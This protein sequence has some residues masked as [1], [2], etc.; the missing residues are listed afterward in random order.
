M[1]CCACVGT[2]LVS[3]N[4]PTST[5]GMATSSKGV[6]ALIV[7]QQQRPANRARLFP[8]ACRSP[9]SKRY[10]HVKLQFHFVAFGPLTINGQVLAR[11]EAGQG[12]AVEARPVSAR[13]RRARA[14]SRERPPAIRAAMRNVT[15]PE[16]G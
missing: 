3:F 4:R 6:V 7:S 12:T 16:R 13:S 14:N 11:L 1:F 15:A 2:S 5:A 10:G 8:P 9:V